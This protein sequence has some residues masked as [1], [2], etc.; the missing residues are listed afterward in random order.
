MTKDNHHHSLRNLFKKESTPENSIP[1]PNSSSH[2]GLSKLFHHSKE[3]HGLSPNNSRSHDIITPP[4]RSSSSLSLKRRNSNPINRNRSNSELANQQQYN[5]PGGGGKKFTKA[6]TFDT[7][8]AAKQ[9]LRNSRIPSNH[10]NHSQIVPP[11]APHPD[12]IV[13]NPYGMNKTPSQELPKN[14][15]FYLSGGIDGERVLQNPVADPNQYLPTE[16]QQA[17]VNLLEDFEIDVSK[18]NLG[19]GGSSD[20]RIINSSHHKKALFAL[21]RFVLLH[22][23]TDEEFYKRVAKEYIIQKKASL[24][25]HVVDVMAILR[26]QSQSNLSRGWGMV[27][28][29]CGGGDLFSMIVKPGWKRTPLNEKYCLFKQISY[30]LLF[31]HQ[32]DIVHRDLKPENVLIDSNGLAKLCDFGVSDYGHEDPQNFDSPIKLSH[33]Y[34]GSPPY[35]PPE[36]MLLK[37]KSHLEAKNFGYNSFKMDCWGLGMLLFCLVYSGLPFQQSTPND[38]AFRDYKFSHKRFCSDHPNF[39]NNHGHPKGPGSEFKFA[40]KFESSGASRVAWKLCDPSVETRYNLKNLFEDPWFISL[41]MCIYESE[42]QLINPFV[43]PGTGENVTTMPKSNQS[44]NNNS[45]VPSRKPTEENLNSSFRSMLDINEGNIGNSS[46]NSIHSGSSV[47]NSPKIRSMLDA[48]NSHSPSLQPNNGALPALEESS[49]ED[50]EEEDV[51]P[52]QEEMKL[53]QINEEKL[54]QIN[55]EKLNQEE[56]MNLEIEK[57][58]PSPSSLTQEPH[59]D[60]NQI[61]VGQNRHGLHSLADLQPKLLKSKSDLKLDKDGLCDLGYKI[62]K[63][64][65]LEVSNT[66]ISGSLRKI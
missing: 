22:K 37:E 13:Y 63:H 24:S 57:A 25:R 32:Q 55:E 48:D 27:M 52:N 33:S 56:Q 40:A 45:Q 60:P 49:I 58:P 4:K 38:H 12:K 17:H 30:G 35:S 46:S 41:E 65:H 15:S 42:D 8:I 43:L 10:N 2:I 61:S 54:N 19:D 28:E 62:K 53:N 1:S 7:R 34:I 59:P 39:K 3:H 11:P 14:T 23:E 5:V 6:E 66:A 16:L 64:H 50:G 20:V 51:L 18:K 29:F 26:I 21:K 47:T 36:V 31:L 44:S 9:H